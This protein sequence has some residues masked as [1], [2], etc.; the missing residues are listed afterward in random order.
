[1]VLFIL[2][3]LRTVYRISIAIDVFGRLVTGRGIDFCKKK[4]EKNT[5]ATRSNYTYKF[6]EQLERNLRQ[7]SPKLSGKMASA[8]TVKVVRVRPGE[9]GVRITTSIKYARLLNYS[10]N[11]AIRAYIDRIFAMTHKQVG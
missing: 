10:L 3:F 6:A 4:R 5:S 11:T 8:W 2:G 7:Y 1:M 9:A